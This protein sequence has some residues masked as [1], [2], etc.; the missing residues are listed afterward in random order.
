VAQAAVANC[1][2]GLDGRLPRLGVGRNLA[3]DQ[4]C[5]KRTSVSEIHC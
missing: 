5:R 3:K 1:K 4:P 2:G